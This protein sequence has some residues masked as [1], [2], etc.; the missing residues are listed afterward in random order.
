MVKLGR[1]QIKAKRLD[2]EKIT[3]IKKPSNEKHGMGVKKR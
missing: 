3:E 1:K 2:D